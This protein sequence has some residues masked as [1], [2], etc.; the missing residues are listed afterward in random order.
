MTLIDLLPFKVD[1]SKEPTGSSG[2]LRSNQAFLF[3]K[4]APVNL[5]LKNIFT[6]GAFSSSSIKI[7]FSFPRSIA[8]MD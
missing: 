5:W 2:V 1:L 4:S 8:F 3:L 6:F 7:E